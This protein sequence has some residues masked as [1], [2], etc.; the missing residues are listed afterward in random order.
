MKHPVC[1][2]RLLVA[3][4]SMLCA[5]TSAQALAQA[6]YPSPEAATDAL[7]G[8]LA[9]HDDAALGHVLGKDWQRLLPTPSRGG[10]ARTLFLE[11][12]AQSRKVVQAEGR[13]TVVVGRDEW[14]LPIPL[15]RTGDG[16][17]FDPVAAREEI[18]TRRIGA[19][20]LAA[21]QASLAYVDA[22]LE[23]AAQD[24]NGDGVLEYAR[25][26]L[27]TPGKRD[28]LI[29]AA[30]QGNDSPLGEAFLPRQQGAGYH[31]YRFRILEAQGAAAPGGARSYLIGK[32]LLSGFA[33]VAWPVHYGVT[34]VMSFIVNQDGVVYERD[35]GPSTGRVAAAMT[36][37][38]PDKSWQR[39]EP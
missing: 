4:L 16:W 12:A 17:R 11:K 5:L 8:A 33:L 19:N 22:Q 1:M 34:G 18:A 38:D 35:L 7:V 27:S 24:R 37:F 36:R 9:T 26:L 2:Q 32:R 6:S 29:W 25:K 3:A 15:V 10:T 14:A 30:A 20:E 13:G 39:I 23:Y 21:M 28:G 31:G